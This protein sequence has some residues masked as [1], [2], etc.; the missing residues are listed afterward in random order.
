MIERSDGSRS[1]STHAGDRA[2]E[3]RQSNWTGPN[4]VRNHVKTSKGWTAISTPIIAY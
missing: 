1:A 2:E 3:S 4:A